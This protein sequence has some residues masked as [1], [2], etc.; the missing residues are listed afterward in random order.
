MTDEPIAIPSMQERTPISAYLV[1]VL[2]IVA[3]SSSAVLIRLAQGEGLPSLLVAA[4]RLVIAAA[5]L[6]PLALRRYRPHLQRLSR[7]DLLLAA[8]SGL[9]LALH[10]ATWVTSLEYTSVLISVVLVT[11]SPLW[12]ALLEVFVLKSRL[13]GLIIMGLLLALAGGVVIGLSGQTDPASGSF[14]PEAT[15]GAALS[16][17]GAVTVSIYLIIGRKLR[18][19]LPV[20][21]YIW[22]V[23]GFAAIIMTAWVLLASVPMTGYSTE[24][25][26]WLLAL[27]LIPQLIGHSSWNYVLGYLPATFV[28]LASQLEPVFSAL[29]ALFLFG[30]QPLPMQ[31]AGS[32]VI[33]GG[34]MLA[35]LGQSRS[36]QT[37]KA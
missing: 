19:Q 14:T 11:T 4:S 27:G 7:F 21:P 35:T 5:I 24:G 20:I 8:I 16:L 10:F 23:Y 33:L 37:S 25:Y 6:T 17:A 32:A 15:L 34:V 30:E 31:V 12:V 29:L 13:T 36:R 2:G 9:F 1:L 26:L 22:L 28:S 18:A 3:V